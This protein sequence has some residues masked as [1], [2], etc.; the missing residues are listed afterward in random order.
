MVDEPV[1]LGDG[2]YGMP[3]EYLLVLQEVAMEYG[4]PPQ[5]IMK[6]TGVPLDALVQHEARIGHRSFSQGIKNLIETIDDPALPILYAKRMTMQRHGALGLA[7]QAAKNLA[8]TAEL[9]TK[10]ID[11]RSG[12][13]QRFELVESDETVAIVF[14]IERQELGENVERFEYLA[15]LFNIEYLGRYLTGTIQEPVATEIH[16][17]SSPSSDIPSDLLLPGLTIKYEQPINQVVTPKE[18]FYR[19]LVTTD[20]G[21]FK[22]AMEQVEKEMI[23]YESVVDIA[24]IVRNRLREHSGKLPSLTQMSEDL[25]LSSSSLKRKLKQ[26]GATYQ[27]LRES[28]LFHK[29]NVLLGTTK[30]TVEQIADMLGYAD[31]SNFNKAF[32]QWSGLTP[33]EYRKQ[34]KQAN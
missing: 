14:T 8:E 26:V 30:Y 25:H 12:G 21:M 10:Y 4:V 11:T 24:A 13:G 19:P 2:Q 20:P 15:L 9:L 6:G 32:K 7:F 28:V 22:V 16:L 18:Y 34:Q 31:P 1:I 5:V 29:A 17:T 3:M 33:S 27:Q 23:P